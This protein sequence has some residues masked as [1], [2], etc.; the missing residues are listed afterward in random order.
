MAH[1]KFSEHDTP[2]SDDGWWASV[3]AEE[4]KRSIQVGANPKLPKAIFQP[5]SDWQRAILL[6]EQ[7]EI[8]LMTVTGYNRG[9]LLVEGK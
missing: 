6:Y 1:N 4:E 7:D 2:I 3:L 9:G 5:S 8:V